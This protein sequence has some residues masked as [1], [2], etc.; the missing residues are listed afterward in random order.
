MITKISDLLRDLIEIEKNKLNE[1]ELHHSPSIGRMYEGLTEKF[2]SMLIPKELNIRVV[3]GFICDDD[4][5]SRQIDCMIVFGDGEEIPY[6]NEYKWDIR[7]VIAVFE[8]KKNLFHSELKSS[9]T[10]LDNVY[11]IYKDQI[12]KDQENGCF[13]FNPRRAALEYSYIFGEEAPQYRNIKTLPIQRSAI[14]QSL[15][16]DLTSPLR[17][18]IGYN[19]FKSEYN[20]RAS[21]EQFFSENIQRTGFGVSNIPHLI[22]S[23]GFSIIKTNGM[24]YHGNWE[25]ELGWGFLASSNANPIYLLMEILFTKMELLFSIRFDWGDDLREELLV[26]LMYGRVITQSG[27]NGWNFTYKEYNK[28]LFELRTPYD[29]WKPF[30]LTKCQH[31]LVTIIYKNNKLKL[32]SPILTEFCKKNDIKNLDIHIN[33]LIEVKIII[34]SQDGI[35]IADGN[36]KFIRNKNIIYGGNNNNGRFDN[37][38]RNNEVID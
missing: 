27:T 10:L 16:R 28:D 22:I 25:N 36:F 4:V 13:S 1:Y 30:T 31:E 24:P 11:Q 38:I 34:K 12:Q 6:T 32:D 15:V 33:Y 19:G 29:D 21:F 17:I 37:W 2:L 9:Y 14:Y 8:I 7:K 35:K 3:S 5:L 20:L 23:D 26:T 18:A